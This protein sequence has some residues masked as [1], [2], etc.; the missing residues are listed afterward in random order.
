MMLSHFFHRI[1]SLMLSVFNWCKPSFHLNCF[2][3][4]NG[5]FSNVSLISGFNDMIPV[6]VG[7]Q[8][9]A[10][11][12]MVLARNIYLPAADFSWGRHR[13]NPSNFHF[14]ISVIQPWVFC[15]TFHTIFDLKSSYHWLWNVTVFYG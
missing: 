8:D 4:R 1:K 3:G 10:M 14:L 12:L 6:F 7:S 9:A 15:Y 2:V 13:M 5:F 11:S